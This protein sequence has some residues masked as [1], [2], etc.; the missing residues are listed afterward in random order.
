MEIENYKE[1]KLH[2]AVTRY[3]NLNNSYFLSH[4]DSYFEGKL[5]GM[6]ISY[7][8]NGTPFLKEEYKFGKLLS[9][10]VTDEVTTRRKNCTLMELYGDLN[11]C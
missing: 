5:H 2:G 3:S 1:G 4:A 7:F 6:Q 11:N 8:A 9:H 10:V